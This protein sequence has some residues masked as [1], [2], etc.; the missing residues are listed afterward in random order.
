MTNWLREVERWRDEVGSWILNKRC[1]RVI[2]SKEKVRWTFEWK[3]IKKIT[4]PPYIELSF[5][6]HKI[7]SMY[8]F[9]LIS[10]LAFPDRS[11]VVLSTFSNALG[12]FSC[13][14]IVLRY[15]YVVCK[16]IPSFIFAFVCLLKL[17]EMRWVTYW[18]QIKYIVYKIYCIFYLPK[19]CRM[20]FNMYVC[21]Q[22]VPKILNR[23]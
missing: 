12:G 19:R 4:S 23:F 2:E 16:T 22:Y 10:M 9:L 11:P 1:K 3:K 7:N 15:I 8:L 20:C 18:L 21:P 14:L 17:P 5:I 13:Q 6:F